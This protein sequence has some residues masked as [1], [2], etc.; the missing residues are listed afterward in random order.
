MKKVIIVRC[1]FSKALDPKL[2]LW[3]HSETIAAVKE[4]G[5]VL[6]GMICVIL[7]ECEVGHCWKRANELS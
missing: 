7:F 1:P 4:S 5:L 2:A 3:V 6:L